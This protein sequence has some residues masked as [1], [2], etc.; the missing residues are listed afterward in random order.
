MGDLADLQIE[1][2][3]ASQQA[4][5][6]NQIHE[7]VV[8]VEGEAL[9]P[10]LEEEAFAHFQQKMLGLADDGGRLCRTL[11]CAGAAGEL[12]C[13]RRRNRGHEETGDWGERFREVS[14]PYS[15]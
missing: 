11:F 3:I 15:P 2:D 5:I 10:R 6:E 4:V 8:F 14:A 9:L 7:E 12:P 1:Q 13:G